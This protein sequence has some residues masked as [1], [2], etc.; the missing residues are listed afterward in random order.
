MAFYRHNTHL[1]LREGHLCGKK[2]VT[3]PVS[4][5]D[6]IEE[7]TVY[8]KLRKVDIQAS[9]AIPVRRRPP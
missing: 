4:Q 9:P 8:L 2:D 6:H 7:D 5:I 3:I 1:V